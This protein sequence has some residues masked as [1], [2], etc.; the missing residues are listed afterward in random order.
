M[1]FVRVGTPLIRSLFQSG[2]APSVDLKKTSTGIISNRRPVSGISVHPESSSHPTSNALRLNILTSA[3]REFARRQL[4]SRFYRGPVVSPFEDTTPN[5]NFTPNPPCTTLSEPP[6]AV[7]RPDYPFDNAPPLQHKQGKG[8][9][10]SKYDPL[11]EPGARSTS[12]PPTDKIGED[13][14]AR[15]AA[16]RERKEEKQRRRAAREELRAAAQAVDSAE[17]EIEDQLRATVLGTMLMMQDGCDRKL[18]ERNGGG[19]MVL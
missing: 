15:K 18:L 10:N 17:I 8:N 16:R 11:P 7:S 1:H 19:M 5:V 4:Y 2:G 9:R 6:A 3:K 14:D 12:T 13:R